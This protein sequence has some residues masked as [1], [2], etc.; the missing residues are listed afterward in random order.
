MSDGKIYGQWSGTVDTDRGNQ[1]PSPE[2]ATRLADALANADPQAV[3]AAINMILTLDYAGRT[4]TSQ[5]GFS[6]YADT[7]GM[8]V[9]GIQSLSITWT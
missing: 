9:L 8:R 4:A 5:G 2:N 7:E 1:P 3:V 6:F